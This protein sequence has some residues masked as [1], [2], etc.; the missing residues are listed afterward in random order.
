MFDDTNPSKYIKLNVTFN[1]PPLNQR[2]F[3]NWSQNVGLLQFQ[4]AIHVINYEIG[5]KDQSVNAFNRI[6]IIQPCQAL[7]L[8][9]PNQPQ[10]SQSHP[11]TS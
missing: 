2:V 9:K 4:Y 10:V 6:G 7:P 3:S 1:R 5:A 8:S 11:S